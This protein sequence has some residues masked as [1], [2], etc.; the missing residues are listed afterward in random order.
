MLFDI[1]NL[2]G[3]STIEKKVKLII[4]EELCRSTIKLIYIKLNWKDPRTPHVH[5][6]NRNWM[7]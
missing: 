2:C 6:A 5:P 1:N 3:A 7:K 4:K